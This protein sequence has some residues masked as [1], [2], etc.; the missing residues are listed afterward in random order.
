MKF[1]QKYRMTAPQLTLVLGVVFAAACAPEVHEGPKPPLVRFQKATYTLLQM[2]AS[3]SADPNDPNT[4][5]LWIKSLEENP[6]HRAQQVSSTTSSDHNHPEQC[7]D[8]SLNSVYESFLSKY[9]IESHEM[10]QEVSPLY[11]R[12]LT[13][14]KSAGVFEASYQRWKASAPISGITLNE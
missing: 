11:D 7:S 1:G 10:D 12:I 4:F 2:A 3:Q 14:M 9:L 6:E 8:V 5:D 13:S